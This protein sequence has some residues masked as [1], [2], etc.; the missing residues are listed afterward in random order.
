MIERARARARARERERERE[1]ARE[2][3]GW[4]R[5]RARERA[6]TDLGSELASEHSALHGT[7]ELL[8]CPITGEREVGDGCPLLWPVCVCVCVC[9]FAR[10]RARASSAADYFQRADFFRMAHAPEFVAAGDRGVHRPGRA[11]YS[12]PVYVYARRRAC[13]EGCWVHVWCSARWMRVGV[14]GE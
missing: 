14:C 7:Q 11:H 4:R 2:R 13:E 1:R 5:E 6:T 12:V 10:A 9:A 3:R 8:R